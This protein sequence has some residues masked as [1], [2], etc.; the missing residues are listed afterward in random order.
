MRNK[1]VPGQDAGRQTQE[2]GTVWQHLIFVLLG[3]G[4]T[5]ETPSMAL[6]RWIL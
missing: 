6:V 3:A 2:I 1:K 5:L 4:S